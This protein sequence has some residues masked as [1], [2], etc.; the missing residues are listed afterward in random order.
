[1]KEAVEPGQTGLVYAT[2]DSDALGAAMAGLAQD[3][4]RRQAFGLA[5]RRRAEAL[6]SADAYVD[7]L[8]RGYAELLSDVGR[9]KGTPRRDK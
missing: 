2:L 9:V 6:F 7:T 5:G 1:M 4:E 3:P 8:Y